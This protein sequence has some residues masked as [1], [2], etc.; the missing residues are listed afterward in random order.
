[1]RRRIAFWFTVV[2]VFAATDGATARPSFVEEP[3]I[4]TGKALVYIFLPK[5]YF[6]TPA[7]EVLA[8]NQP[9]TVLSQGEYVPY[10]TAPG[11]IEFSTRRYSSPLT[12]QVAAGN[13]YFLK[14]STHISRW[15]FELL[16]REQALKEI[17]DC[18]RAELLPQ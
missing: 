10:F 7:A 4:P 8:G 13:A 16:S 3:S 18:R 2:A 17:S 1:M 11:N 12:V 6:H 15:I 9:V 14:L 5:T